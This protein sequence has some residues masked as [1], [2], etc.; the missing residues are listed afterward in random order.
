MKKNIL[1]IAA[2]AT[3][4]LAATY[5]TLND[6]LHT[7]T[8]VP[9]G[10]PITVGNLTVGS[11]SEAPG[12]GSR[13]VGDWTPEY[14][15]FND[16]D[17]LWVENEIQTIRTTYQ[18]KA[19]A[20]W[21]PAP[22][23]D[24]VLFYKDVNAF[25]TDFFVGRKGNISLTPIQNTFAKY[26]EADRIIGNLQ[27]I[28]NELVNRDGDPL[29]HRHVD[30]VID[31]IP[32][33]DGGHWDGI[34]FVAHMQ[35]EDTEV[36]FLTNGTTK[37]TPFLASISPQKATYRAVIPPYNLP[38]EGNPIISITSKGAQEIK[39]TYSNLSEPIDSG[40]RLIITLN[41]DNKRSLTTTATTVE[42][43]GKGLDY[44]VQH[45]GYMLINNAEGLKTFRDLVNVDKKLDIKAV[46]T[47]D[48][49]LTEV[50]EPIGTGANP[51]KGT[52]NGNGYTITGLNVEGGTSN[53]QGLFGYTNGAILTG[54]N[55]I[56]PAVTGGFNVGALVGF[57]ATDNH[58]SNC[59]VQGGAIEGEGIIGG[60]VG[61]NEGKIVACYA[62]NITVTADVPIGYAGGL[63]GDTFNGAI[64]FCYAT[65]TVTGGYPGA[66]VGVNDGIIYSCY[67]ISEGKP[68][69]SLDVGT[70]D[71]NS[72]SPTDAGNTV[73]S[74][75]GTETV[76][77]A[78][79]SI[80]K[81][82]AGIWEK[83][84]AQPKLIW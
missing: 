25:E 64:T 1:S 82:D 77:T 45:N 16:G 74:Y 9:A 47:A 53:F 79:N 81:I 56:E 59:S 69:V 23:F 10:T 24:E 63:V 61:H 49:T 76:N 14:E 26:C 54:I 80:R 58:I 35:D 43:W 20:T 5:C 78:L 65:G 67:A 73:R 70:G 22:D 40:K 8:D 84:V 62:N 2:I 50:W 72:T 38:A 83:G 19:P 75:K 68:L 48:I 17:K 21:V 11:G 60:L 42:A 71:K 37:V 44:E 66:L 3:L 31:I 34:D 46:Q 41:Y 27:L 6:P 30:V 57:A 33:S 7:N 18:F 15:S 28:G 4:L 32:Q 51:F 36:R 52:Y 39:G 13:A 55:L 12:P 29:T